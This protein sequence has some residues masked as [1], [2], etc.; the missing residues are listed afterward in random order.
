MI[1]II[2]AISREHIDSVRKLFFEYAKSLNVST[3]FENFDKEVENLP[4]LYGPPKGRLLIALSDIKVAGCIAL[5]KVDDQTCEMKRLFVRHE[6]RGQGVGKELTTAVWE[7]ARGTGYKKMRLDTLPSMKEAIALYESLG[8][9]PIPPY[10]ELPVPG[11][12]F[13]QVALD[14]NVHLKER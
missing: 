12:L 8:F 5:K 11:A 7:E 14:R 10:R 9:E 4:R 3:C 1:K 13:M 2:Q 6:F